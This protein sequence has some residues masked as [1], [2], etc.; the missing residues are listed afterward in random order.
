M[1]RLTPYG[2]DSRDIDVAAEKI[3]EHCPDPGNNPK[4]TAVAVLAAIKADRYRRDA[5]RRKVW[6]RQALR[7]GGYALLMVGLGAIFY[8]TAVSR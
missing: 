4:I 5:E 8:L 2:Y 7:D 3:I 6:W 1:H